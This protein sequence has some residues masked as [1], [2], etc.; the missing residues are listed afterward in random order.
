MSCAV[1]VHR[2]SAKPSGL[3]SCG[4]GESSGWKGEDTQKHCA[5]PGM[6]MGC[7]NASQAGT[8]GWQTAAGNAE[9]VGRKRGAEM[10][11]D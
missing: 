10:M 9:A 5:N 2:N 4:R 3:A 1:S 8:I 6:Q 7:R 11:G